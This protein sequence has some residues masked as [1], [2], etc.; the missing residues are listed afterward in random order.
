VS[1]ADHHNLPFYG[2][3]RDLLAG[4]GTCFQLIPR[5]LRLIIAALPDDI[6]GYDMA[7]TTSTASPPPSPIEPITDIL[8]G[9]PVTDPYRWLEDQNSPRTRKWLEAQGV[10][11]RALLDALPGRERVRKRVEELLVVETVSE[12]WKVGDRY[13]Y[14]KRAPRQQQPVIAMRVGESGKEVILVES[15]YNNGDTAIAVGIVN[16]SSEGN[17]L[18]YSV[19]RGG[20]DSQSVQFLDVTRMQLLPDSLPTGFGPGLVFRPDG[21]GFYYSHEIVGS[22][23]PNHRA[24]YRH[25]FGTRPDEDTE[26]FFAGEGPDLHVRLGGSPDSRLLA[27]GVDRSSDPVRMD[28]YL[29]DLTN[30]HSIR[31]VLE[32]SE[33]FFGPAFAGHTLVALTDCKAPNR[34][35]VA[36]DPDRPD[37]DHWSVIVPESKQRINDFTVVGGFVC[38]SYV[39]NLSSRIELFDLN[40]ESYDAL[41]CP[42]QGTARLLGRPVGS[43]TLFYS[44][45]SFQE[46]PTIFAY[47]VP[48][49]EQRVWAKS[50]VTFDSS[51]I[52]VDQVRYKSKDGT[53]VPMFLVAQKRKHLE[54]PLPTFLTAYGGFGVSVTPQFNAYS[55]FLIEQGFLLAFA[56]VRGGGEFGEEWHRAGKRHNRQNA[57]GDFIS[58]AEW[59]V[60]NGYSASETMV[61]G[62]GSNG[63]LLVGAAL[64]QR[65]ELFRAVVC[66]GPVLDMLRYHHSQ[67]ANSW[68]D[69][70]GSPDDSEDFGHLLSYSPYHHVA[71]GRQYPSVMLVSGDADTRCDPMHAR[72][73]TAR[74]QAATTS[75]HP[76]LLDYKSAW[77]HA[78]SQPLSRRIDALT[79]RL[80]FICHESSVRV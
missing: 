52:Q 56:N 18:A 68:I 80:A 76:I 69:E 21:L 26:V 72:K 2:R 62:G 63:G 25:Q 59:L 46:P 49:R 27:Y 11:T 45:S 47:H 15:S 29:Q 54:H 1:E 70:Y 17:I 67:F 78:P 24:V 30:G 12:P 36:I 40:G 23:R 77:G 4:Y 7:S 8:H 10:Y 58:A 13:F 6:R 43:D 71:E 57:I 19:K 50:S 75:S 79:D 28:L 34:R 48:T 16:V 42:P 5:V 44:F 31:K 38:V 51:S 74:L 35:V 55:T 66:I 53:E 37:I 14:L 61:I 73:M 32:G 20:T 60:K 39:E 22:S 3:I 33:S 64:T 65:P 41:P 9:V